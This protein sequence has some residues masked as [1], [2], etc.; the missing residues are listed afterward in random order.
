[1]TH[2]MVTAPQ[3]EAV[4]AGLDVL[5]SGGNV[6]DAAVTA[7]LVQTV[8]DPQMCGIAGF[9]SMQIFQATT[10]V[11]HYIDFHGRAPRATRED[12]WES[13]IL[14]EC[15]D[16]FGFIL[17]GQVNEIG[18]R[19]MTTPLTLKALAEGLETYGTRSLAEV[20]EPAIGYC[21]EGFAVRPAVHGFWLQP[22]Q[23]GR[24]ERVRV[25]KDDPESAR[26]YL[27]PDGSL[28]QVGDILK[29]PDMGR[30]YRRIAD[31]GMEDFY[32][33]DIAR[34]IDA[35][36]R[37]NGGLI[38]LEDLA[39]CRPNHTEPLKGSY[40]GFE[41]ATNQLPGGG[42]MILE[43][44]NILENFDLSAMGHNSADYISAVAEAMKIATVDKDQLMGDPDFIDVPM[45]KLMSKDY[46]ATQAERIR[47]GEKGMC[48]GS[49]PAHRKA[50]KRLISVSPMTPGMW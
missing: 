1:M 29:N 47:A 26:I 7:A 22:A 36:M 42:L 18:Y 10:G 8:V 20:L 11:H 3:P 14:G 28:Y 37:K 30:T 43:M 25:I 46:A 13:L 19:S 23:A 6:M 44:L 35:D 16:G 17:D 33:G 39:D 31:A 49:I 4:E 32:S 38:T 21:E 50:R 2:G 15:D 24:I 27:K 34:E 12:M 45:E 41:I 9:G 5:K 40:R 48:L